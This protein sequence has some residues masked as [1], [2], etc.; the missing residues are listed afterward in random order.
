MRSRRRRSE[1]KAWNSEGVKDHQSV[2]FIDDTCVIFYWNVW[3]VSTLPSTHRKKW[4]K[5]NKENIFQISNKFLVTIQGIFVTF[6]PIRTTFQNKIV[7]ECR[8]R[9]EK[10][11]NSMLAYNLMKLFLWISLPTSSSSIDIHKWSVLRLSIL[12]WSCRRSYKFLSWYDHYNAKETAWTHK[13]Y[14]LVFAPGQFFFLCNHIPSTLLQYDGNLFYFVLII[15]DIDLI[16]QIQ[17][18]FIEREID[19]FRFC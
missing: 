18:T 6:I 8:R 10:R 9:W 15:S 13:I 17:A 3:L 1:R 19:D 7:A 14:T 16:F 5:R 4:K 12:F 2:W 11:R